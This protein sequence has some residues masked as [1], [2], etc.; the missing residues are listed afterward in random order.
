MINRIATNM[1]DSYC[2]SK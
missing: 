2:L 1:T